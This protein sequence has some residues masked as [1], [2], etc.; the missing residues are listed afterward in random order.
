MIEKAEK[1]KNGTFVKSG[2][3]IVEPT[4]GNTGIALDYDCD[5]KDIRL[6]IIMPD[7]YDV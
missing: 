6:I 1:K 7:N 4:S 5:L 3:V 2:D